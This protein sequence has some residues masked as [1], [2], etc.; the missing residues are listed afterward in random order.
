MNTYQTA[1][2]AVGV[3]RTLSKSS[4]CTIVVYQAGAGKYVTA[5]P[6]DSVSGLVIGVFRNGYLL[7]SGHR[8]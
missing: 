4:A 5:R 8:A 1:N 6:T 7:P 2:Q 3:A